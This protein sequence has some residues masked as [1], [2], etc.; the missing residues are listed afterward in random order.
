RV[1][2]AG[3]KGDTVIEAE[4]VRPS[5]PFRNDRAAAIKLGQCDVDTKL[6][7]YQVGVLAPFRVDVARAGQR[8]PV[9]AW[10]EPESVDALSIALPAAVNM[11]R[12]V[13]TRAAPD[14]DAELIAPDIDVL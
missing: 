5:P 2:D 6:S 14:A 12:E 8:I 3:D 9:R 7:G 11:R 4:H 10:A 13:A 1:R